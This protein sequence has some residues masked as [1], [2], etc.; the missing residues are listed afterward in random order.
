MTNKMQTKVL[1]FLLLL[2][3]SF[4]GLSQESTIILPNKSEYG[5]SISLR[6]TQGN[7]D[8]VTI[9]VILNWN[10]ESNLIQVEFKSNNSNKYIYLFPEVDFFNEIKKKEANLWF[11]KNI[12]KDSPQKTVGKY[13]NSLTNV[14]IS[15]ENTKKIKY[16]GLKDPSSN[17]V[18]KFNTQDPSKN[19]CFISMRVYVAALEKEKRKFLFI[20]LSSDRDRK[21]EYMSEIKLNI[22]LQD[23]CES[24]DLQKIIDFLTK[25]RAAL[26]TGTRE[27]TSES[28]ELPNL[29]R[30]KIKELND[31]QLIGKDK[32]LN[33][34]NDERYVQYNDCENLK[35]AIRENNTAMESYD[36]AVENYNTI[37]EEQKKR[38]AG[39]IIE[40]TGSCPTI[41]SANKKLKTLYYKIQRS[42]Q[43]NLSSFQSEYDGIVNGVVRD[44]KCGSYEAYKTWCSGIEKFLKK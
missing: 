24:A 2:T 35:A 11:S 27:I 29:S 20:P 37:L 32:I 4:S 8:E 41:E 9:P 34:I 10:K 23:V 40:G 19:T 30:K 13:L 36:N 16:Y 5:T 1:F 3:V 17:T 28:E 31:K 18:F 25:E 42:D 14:A 22:T 6:P 33:N 12:T 44:E 38:K 7:G 26:Q 39:S 43:S 21:I 15:G